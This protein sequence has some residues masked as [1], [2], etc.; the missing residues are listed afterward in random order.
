MVAR[1]L[2]RLVSLFFLALALVAWAMAAVALV[3]QFKAPGFD[4][5]AFCAGIVMPIMAFMMHQC[6]IDAWRAA[7]YRRHDT[8][9]RDYP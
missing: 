4:L 2:Y 6:S 9:W 5:Q 1:F 3:V 7:R 8:L